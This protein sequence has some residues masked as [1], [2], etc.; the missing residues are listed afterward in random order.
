MRHDRPGQNKSD[1]PTWQPM[2][3]TDGTTQDGYPAQHGSYAMNDMSK[4]RKTNEM[5]AEGNVRSELPTDRAP[6]QPSELAGS[7]T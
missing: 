7:R 6:E 4:M 3:P 5:M 2:L 1:S